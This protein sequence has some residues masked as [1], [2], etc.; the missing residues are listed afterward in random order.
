MSDCLPNTGIGNLPIVIGVGFALLVLGAVLAFMARRKRRRGREAAGAAVIVVALV[1]TMAGG[2]VSPSPATASTAS[3][4]GQSSGAGSTTTPPTSPATSTPPAEGADSDG[5]GLPDDVEKRLGTD[6]NSADTDG[7]G[8]S[9]AEEVAATTNPLLKDSDGDG[10][11]DPA[12]DID[13]DGLDTA[14]EIGIA[15][16]PYQADSDADHLTDDRELVSETKPLVADTDGDHLLDGDEVALGSD[17]KKADTDGDGITDDREQHQHETRDD[18]LGATVNATAEGDASLMVQIRGAPELDAVHGA[19]A[20]AVEVVPA[21]PLTSATVTMSFDPAAASTGTQLAVMHFDSATGTFDQP[22]DQ[23]IDIARG[24]ATIRTDRFSPFVI[25]DI[26]E[27]EQVWK[28]EIVVPREGGDQVASIDSGLAIDSSGSMLDN[29]PQRLRLEAAKLFVD[30]LLRGDRIAVV[31]FDSSAT[32]LQ[33]LTEDLAAAKAAIDQVDSDGGTDIGAGLLAT[34]DQLPADP[35]RGRVAVLLTDG[36]GPYDTSLTTRAKDAGVVV[37]TVGLGSSVDASLLQA[38]AD[39]TG[40]KYFYVDQA[41]GLEDAY[42]RIIE[43]LGKPDTDKD[44]I[45]DEAETTGWRTGRGTVHVTDP[46]N[47]DTDG[48][49]LTDGQE[50]GQLRTGGA[51]GKGTYYQGL[52]DPTKPDSDGDGLYDPAEFDFETA[53]LN[54]DTDADGLG[55]LTE[56]EYGYLPTAHNPDGDTFYDKAELANGTDPFQYDLSGGEN[57]AAVMGGFVFGDWDWG[58]QHIGRLSER[59]RQ[60]L[61][62]LTGHLASGF[63]AVGDLRDLIANIGKGA[64]GDAAWSAAALVPVFGDAAR[65]GQKLV[66]FAAKGSHEV[67][68]ALYAA[69]KMTDPTE[70][71]KASRAIIAANPAAARVANDVAVRGRQAAAPNNGVYAN[72]ASVKISNDL[73]QARKLRDLITSV[74]GRGALNIRV[75]QWQADTAGAY[76]G[77]NRPDLQ[78]D[79]NGKHYLVEF[80][81]PLK[82]NSN[83]TRRGIPHYQRALANDPSLSDA[84]IQLKVVGEFERH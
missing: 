72:G 2:V 29:D 31:D 11:P 30:S 9:D 15:T 70:A 26:A 71:R 74:R 53:P 16:R 58:A 25:V 65:S 47:A 84:Q 7:D 63:L 80:D 54:A 13:G 5:D 50:A 82:S 39:G 83:Q 20:P 41:A 27:F 18:A 55:D 6:P 4:C 79:L 36:L 22:A 28:N 3:S 43:D 66:K 51:F 81:R 57:A 60:S 77:K 19:I 12:D 75:N 64:W 62:Y 37:Y 61:A 32:V 17:P 8:L 10:V 14:R 23:S 56:T 76:V 68:A 78:Y 1:L 48:D 35:A 73:E 67:R 46:A 40:G 49:G 24:T 59:Q 42:E 38:I 44:G 33:P 69:T 52:S 34:L 45:A 21:K